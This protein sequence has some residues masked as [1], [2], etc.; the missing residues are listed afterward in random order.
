[1]NKSTFKLIAGGCCLLYLLAFLFLP[2]IAL[3]LVGIGLS[4]LN[5]FSINALAYIPLAAAVAMLICTF[6]LPGKTA[7]IVNAVG[8]VVPLIVFF[9]FRDSLV[10]SGLS[11]AGAIVPGFGSAVSGL[12]AAAVSSILTVGAGVVLP[13]IAGAAAALLCFLSD[14]AQKPAERTAGLGASTD[15]DW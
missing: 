15:D 10:S 14:N 6:V 5:C 4:G 2:F 12:G 1:M 9:L 7:C 3:K 8:A 11:I 13:V